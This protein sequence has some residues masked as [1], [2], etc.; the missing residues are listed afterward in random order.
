[1]CCSLRTTTPI[2]PPFVGSGGCLVAAEHVVDRTP[3]AVRLPAVGYEPFPVVPDRLAH[4]APDRERV[5]T[6]RVGEVSGSPSLGAVKREVAETGF[7]QA[8]PEVANASA[9]DDGGMV[10]RE[11]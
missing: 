2:S 4:L 10:G 9:P 7:Q 1:M 6:S 5:S 8:Q 3:R 11:K